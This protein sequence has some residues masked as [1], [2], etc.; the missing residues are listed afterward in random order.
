MA[1]TL[2]FK[3]GLVATIPTALAGEPLF[4]TDTFDLYIGNGTSNTRFQKYIASGT[5][6]QL[7][8][9]DGSLLTMPIV[10]TSPATGQ[11]L[12][13]NGTNWVNDSD[14][15]ITGSGS[16][17][18]VAYFTGATTQ[19]GSSNLFWD[20]TNGRLGIGTNT[21]SH[22]INILSSNAALGFRLEHATPSSASFPFQITNSADTNYIR[23]NVNIIELFRNGGASTIR[24]KG[25]NNE[26]L[27]QSVRHLQLAVN[28]GTIAAQLFST[29][30]LVLQ[31]GGTFTDSGQRLQVTGDT[32]LRGS[33]NTS[34]T[35]SLKVQNS[36][37]AQYFNVQN[38]GRVD[39]NLLIALGNRLTFPFNGGGIEWGGAQG[40][41][42]QNSSIVTHSSVFGFVFSQTDSV[43]ALFGSRIAHTISSIF[44]PP[45][46]TALHISSNIN[47]TINQTGGANG[48][49]RGLYVNPTL[50]AAA[51]WRSIEWSNN[52]GWGL[53]GAG[54]APN[55]LNGDLGI[56]TT[57][58]TERLTISYN[59]NVYAT[60]LSIT[61]TNASNTALSGFSLTV[62]GV[63]GG[64]ISYQPSNYI[65]AAQAS[66]LLVASA[67]NNRIGF[68]AN[69]NQVGVAQDIFFST[70]G[71]NTTYQLTV[72]GNTGNILVNSN[73]DTGERLQVNGT[74]RITGASSFGGNMALTNNQ[75]GTT[76][77]T[78]SNTTSGTASFVEFGLVSNSTSGGFYLGKYSSAK[79]PYKAVSVTDAY[80]LNNIAGDIFIFN[81]FSSGGIKFAAGGSSTEQMRLTS[82]G[83]LCVGVTSGGD[84]LNIAAST[85]AKAQI[86]LAAGTAP[87]SPNDGDI[88][89]DG[90]NL[91]MRIGGVTRTFTLT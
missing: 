18:Q 14:A 58:P 67:G 55:Y 60:G 29:G 56:G 62:N 5:T 15:G 91:R 28:D 81:D 40:S 69:S 12:K 63:L 90:T 44:A 26:L 22:P 48:I 80:L 89:F 74:A 49:T 53:Y 76:G 61:N 85:T 2:R 11:V 1:N 33:G 78:I 9:G 88:W 47:P 87:T 17:G 66:S 73:T 45:S 30:N 65:L 20:N 64:V 10:L 4:T 13:F 72:K 75:N 43:N 25:S 6:S 82:A 34:A 39:I 71:S 35:S 7:L 38:N 21:P 19:G 70:F 42:I 52:T 32:L 8:R 41:I 51:D 57:S 24:T 59:N 83:N 36:D 79:N 50:T 31:N 16:A 46:G 84:F 86:F 3:R 77:Y 54:T 37:G 23:A 68:V 27:I